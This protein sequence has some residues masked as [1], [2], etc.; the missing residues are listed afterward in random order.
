VDKDIVGGQALL[1]FRVPCIVA[2]PFTKA[3][4]TRRAVYGTPQGQTVPFDHTSVLKLIEWRYGLDPLSARDASSDVGNL[5]DVF[6]F[7]APDATVPSS[8]PFPLPPSATTPGSTFVRRVCSRAG[9]CPDGT[10][11]CRA[12]RRP[13]GQNEA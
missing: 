3:S 5:V 13:H 4:P 1:G 8:I 7:S 12:R 10:G 11:P 6:D 9:S 2:S